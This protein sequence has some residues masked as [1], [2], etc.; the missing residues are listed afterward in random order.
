MK[1]L[2]WKNYKTGLYVNYHRSRRIRHLGDGLWNSFK[3]ASQSGYGQ[4][5]Q[6]TSDQSNKIK[7]S[8]SSL[9]A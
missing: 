2:S 1:V 4:T 9:Q 5:K 8:R 3:F 6:N 7:E